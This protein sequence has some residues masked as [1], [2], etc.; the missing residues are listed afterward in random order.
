MALSARKIKIRGQVQGVGF[1]PFVFNLAQRLSVFGSVAN[2]VQ[3]VSIYAQAPP[4][5]LNQFEAQLQS[6]QPAMALIESLTSETASIDPSLQCFTIQVSEAGEVDLGV[7]PD[8]TVCRACLAELFDP[9]NPRYQYPFINCTH[10]GPRYSIVKALPYDRKYTTMDAFVL[11]SGCLSEYESP[12]DRRFHAQPNACPACGPQLAL[13][14]AEGLV[15]KSH[16]PIADALALIKQGKIVALKG[17]GGFHL[18]CDATNE[19]AVSRLRRLKNRASKPFA[20]MAANTQSLAELIELSTA[21]RQRLEAL[22]APILLCPQLAGKSVLAESIAPDLAWLGV[23]LPHSPLHYLIFHKAAGEPVGLSWLDEPQ[24]LRL[25]MTSANRSGNPLVF[26]NEQALQALKGIA[27]AFLLHDRDIHIRCDDSVISAVGDEMSLVRRGRGL[28]PQFIPLS[29]KFASLNKSVLAVGSLY[30]N[31]IC[32]TKGDRA[33]VSQYI[34]DLDNPECCRALNTTVEH[35]KSLLQIEPEIVISD[36]H[37]DFYS[38][39]FAQRYSQQ[40]KIPHRQ[41]QHHHAHIAAVIAEHKFDQPI[42]GLALDGFGLGSDGAL[43]GGELLLVDKGEFQRLAHLD[44]L[45]MPG[46]EQAAKEPWRMAAGVIYQLD[47]DDSITQRYPTQSGAAVIAQLLKKQLNCPETTSAGRLFDAVAGLLGVIE[48]NHFE[49]QAAMRLESLAYQYRADNPWPNEPLL[50]RQRDDLTLDCLPLLQ[51]LSECKD[52]SYGAALFHHQFAQALS[53]WVI[54]HSESYSIKHIVLAGGC[55]LNQILLSS[56]K[57]LLNGAGLSIYC[58]DKLPCN[59][60]AVSLG[61]AQVI[62]EKEYRHHSSAQSDKQNSHS[63]S[64][65]DKTDLVEIQQCV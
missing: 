37:P 63:E 57:A 53:N 39:Q 36:L 4:S 60:G 17:V 56:L 50:I 33:Y 8:A 20:V 5:V 46:G 16:D 15:Q 30:K 34:G 35:L 49:A 28:S 44:P 14:N 2:G 12:Q 59:D 3:G 55:F 26:E 38:T 43:W 65:I 54:S 31:T 19:A 1:R 52:P 45:K 23:M 48:V 47:G 24:D 58:A 27:D 13:H 18:T 42:L 61:Q 51:R 7:T 64:E 62:L 32:L 10:C 6:E 25:L 9:E 41:V 40:H 21:R 11:C 29:Y 22:D